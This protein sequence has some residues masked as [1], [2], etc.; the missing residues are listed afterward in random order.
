MPTATRPIHAVVFDLDDTLFLERRY[1]RSGYQAVEKHLARLLH[2]PGPWADWM[3]RRFARGQRQ[4]LFDA[5]NEHFSLGLDRNGIAALVEVYRNHRPDIQPAGGVVA[6][7]RRLRKK[8][9][10][11][12]LLSDGFLPAQRYKLQAVGLA[13]EFD[14]IVFTEELGRSAWKPSPRGFRRMRQLLGVRH[15]ELAYVADNP[16]KDFLA[17]NKLGWKSVQWIRRGQVHAANPSP[18]GGKP[19]IIVHSASELL[20]YLTPTKM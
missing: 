14:A 12:G 2:R 19:Q 4:G 1:V 18:P 10:K 8:G 7:L 11:L 6:I 17:P 9:F 16:A 5:L 20:D 13:G 3:W 15:D